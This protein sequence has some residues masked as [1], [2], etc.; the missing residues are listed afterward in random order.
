MTDSSE[1][2]VLLRAF[3]QQGDVWLL[4]YRCVQ[5]ISSHVSDP[6]SGSVQFLDQF[7]LNNEQRIKNDDMDWE[8]ITRSHESGRKRK[9]EI[10]EKDR[11][12]ESQP[13][14]ERILSVWDKVRPVAGIKPAT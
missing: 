1:I 9:T 12:G 2:D 14:E 8:R 7:F 3:T 13:L 6:V 4:L 10:E 11:I 5:L